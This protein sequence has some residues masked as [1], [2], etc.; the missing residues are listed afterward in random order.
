MS[1]AYTWFIIRGRNYGY[2]ALADRTDQLLNS[3]VADVWLL[4]GNKG[5]GA[6]NLSM[7]NTSVWTFLNTGSIA[8]IAH[9]K[10]IIEFP[11]WRKLRPYYSVV[12]TN[13]Q[14]EPT[15]LLYNGLVCPAVK[16][17]DQKYAIAGHNRVDK[18]EVKQLLR[19]QDPANLSL[20][21]DSFLAYISS[22]R[23]Y[24]PNP[25]IHDSISMNLAPLPDPTAGQ[26]IKGA[27][28]YILL[29]SFVLAIILVTWAIL[30]NQLAF[31]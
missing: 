23:F 21:L 13:Y 15:Q 25:N 6:A 20:Q 26:S 9:N 12:L 8:Y 29:P 18:A 28:F 3:G 30:T 4:Y 31:N 14:P 10:L 27:F 1:L 5:V 22:A 24:D 17:E 2:Q 11:W 7:D 19:M 16:I